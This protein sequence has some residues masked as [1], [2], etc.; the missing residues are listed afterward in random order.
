MNA[1]QACAGPMHFPKHVVAKLKTLA[2][3][4]FE[5][6]GRIACDGSGDIALDYNAWGDSVHSATRF[7]PD[8]TLHGPGIRFHT[9]PFEFSPPSGSDITASVEECVMR[10]HVVPWLFI[11]D[12]TGI[13]IGQ[14]P[15]DIVAGIQSI[16]ATI[17]CKKEPDDDSRLEKLQSS[18]LFKRVVTMQRGATALYTSL[19]KSIGSVGKNKEKLARTYTARLHKLYGL[20]IVFFPY[21]A[22]ATKGI[23]VSPRSSHTRSSFR[24]LQA[25]T[26]KNEDIICK[27]VCVVGDD[28]TRTI[29]SCDVYV[30][31]NLSHH[32]TTKI[33]TFDK[34]VEE[35]ITEFASVYRPEN[36]L[37]ETEPK[38]KQRAA[39]ICKKLMSTWEHKNKNKMSIVTWINNIA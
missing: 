32:I 4:S 22:Y 7:L 2:Q 3:N 28:R 30:F 26:P 37:H 24:A 13:H 10:D 33:H 21:S 35:V 27:G 31:N 14:L 25:P 18:P 34:T 1:K 11:A 15:H 39:R 8:K 29:K 23:T 16:L 12:R 6:G 20:S 17:P 9:H 36:I 5:T 19:A 38:N